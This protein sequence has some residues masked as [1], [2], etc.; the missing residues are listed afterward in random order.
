MNTR[1]YHR[2]GSISREDFDTLCEV[3]DFK[4]LP[5]R[6]P[7]NAGLTQTNGGIPAAAS[8]YR[9]SGLEWLSSYRPRSPLSPLRLD[10]LSEVKYRGGPKSPKKFSQQTASS[11]QIV[12]PPNFLF[13]L[14]PRPF[15]EMWPQKRKRKRRLNID[16]FKRALLELWAKNHGIASN[17]VSQLFSPLLG[18]GLGGGLGGRYLATSPT[19]M[20]SNGLNNGQGHR[21]HRHVRSV[22]VQQTNL[23]TIDRGLSPGLNGGHKQPL[24]SASNRG[25]SSNGPR[26]HYETRTKRFFRRLTRASRRVH[27]IRRL[28]RRIRRENIGPPLQPRI[29]INPSL[30]PA[31]RPE[32]DVID[33]HDHV[34][35]HDLHKVPPPPTLEKQRERV[36]LLEKQVVHQQTEISG[37]RDVVDDLRSSLHLSDA[38]NLALQVLLKKMAKAEVQ[39]PVIGKN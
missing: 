27:F 29:A 14:G 23:D 7:S 6:P 20:T 4:N 12:E 37:L 15:W 22:R 25:R 35:H 26:V 3:L 10:K 8:T 36:H 11:H 2:C 5:S 13:T 28:S 17:R 30:R 18:N 33:G 9:L 1:S 32:T 38:Q 34:V 16:D 39:L 21:N 19:S 24:N 31:P